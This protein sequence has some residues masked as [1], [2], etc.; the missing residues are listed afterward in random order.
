MTDRDCGFLEVVKFASPHNRSLTADKLDAVVDIGRGDEQRAIQV[1][2]MAPDPS[3]VP[4]GLAA[5]PHA[6][7]GFVADLLSPLKHG[8]AHFVNDRLDVL[9]RA[10]KG[11]EVHLGLEGRAQMEQLAFSNALGDPA[12]SDPVAELAKAGAKIGLQAIENRR[13]PLGLGDVEDADAG[14]RRCRPVS[15]A[16]ARPLPR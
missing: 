13:V 11:R 3:R 2:S 16:L 4:G 5:G 1:L 14:Q 9:H 7:A 6:V 10:I 15:R 8:R 12:R